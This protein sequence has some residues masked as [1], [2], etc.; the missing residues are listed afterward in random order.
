MTSAPEAHFIYAW[1]GKMPTDEVARADNVD[2]FE[3]KEHG[4]VTC[5]RF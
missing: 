5:P 3:P 1:A 4:L 2:P